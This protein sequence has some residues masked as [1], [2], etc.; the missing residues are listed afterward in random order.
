[1]KIENNGK[2]PPRRKRRLPSPGEPGTRASVR[3]FAKETAAKIKKLICKQVF[4]LLRGGI[5]YLFSFAAYAE[6]LFIQQTDHKQQKQTEH[7]QQ[8]N[9]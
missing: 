3:A 7:K 4:S 1:L 2:A 5:F 6:T 9:T 8:E